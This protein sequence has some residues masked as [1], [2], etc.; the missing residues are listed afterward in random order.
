MGTRAA[1]WSRR[2]GLVLAAP[3]ADGPACVE[4]PTVRLS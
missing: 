2:L 4:R 3:Q 1:W